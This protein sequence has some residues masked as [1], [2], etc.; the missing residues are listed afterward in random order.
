MALALAEVIAVFEQGKPRIAW[1]LLRN[2]GGRTMYTD[3]P[4]PPPPHPS[5]QGGDKITEIPNLEVERP[6]TEETRRQDRQLGRSDLDT[7]A[8]RDTA[9][10]TEP[11][12]II[13]TD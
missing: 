5:F 10:Q 4:V 8:R 12:G 9:G 1:T 13:Q 7:G 3:Y 2:L 6:I 11:Q